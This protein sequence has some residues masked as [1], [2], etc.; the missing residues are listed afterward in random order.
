MDQR[1]VI[2]IAACGTVLLVTVAGA[3]GWAIKQKQ[4]KTHICIEAINAATAALARKD[5]RAASVQLEVAKDAC[6]DDRTGDLKDLNRQAD[7]AANAFVREAAEAEAQKAEAAAQRREAKEKAAHDRERDKALA[8]HKTKTAREREIALATNIRDEGSDG[9]RSGIIAAGA[10]QAERDGLER[11]GLALIA[12]HGLK[13]T[14]DGPSLSKFLAP[15]IAAVNLIGVRD[16]DKVF[17]CSPGLATK[18]PDTCRGRRVS[19]SGQ[20]MQI[21]KE[22]GMFHGTMRSGGVWVY[23]ITPG[24]TRGLVAESGASFVGLFAHKWWYGN[25]AGGKTESIVVVGRFRGQPDSNGPK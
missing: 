2:V 10:T 6:D 15:V 20:I 25:A 19:V 13:N 23:F 22:Q 4:T 1:T 16:L 9:E 5:V 12:A 14:E 3:T 11:L 17:E 7:E 21:S 8:T 24:E 18:D